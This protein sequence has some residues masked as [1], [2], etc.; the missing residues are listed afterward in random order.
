ML[1][2]LAKAAI[3]ALSKTDESAARKLLADPHA[4]APALFAACRQLLG[5][6]WVSWEPETI[7]HELDG[8]GASEVNYEKALAACVTVSSGAPWWEWRAFCAACNAFSG[9]PSDTSGLTPPEPED[10]AAGVM[11]L[12]LVYGMGTDSTD[13][14]P[15]WS[16]EVEAYVAASLAHHG[17]CLAPDELYFAQE[18]LLKL[19][20]AEGREVASQAKERGAA[21]TES[22]D[23]MPTASSVA[24]E[25][26]AAVEAYVDARQQ[27]CAEQLEAL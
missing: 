23:S 12:T 19:L 27:L 10:M 20:S 22:D 18:R 2:R 24:N 5:P 14:N 1:D 3:S 9:I 7:R 13:V 21:G 26:L 8:L 16:D 15:E 4:T 25:R 11:D 17:F 6:T